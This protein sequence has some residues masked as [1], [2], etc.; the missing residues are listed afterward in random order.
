M[1]TIVDKAYGTLGSLLLPKTPT[2]VTFE[3]AIGA[4]KK[5]Y[6]PKIS[7]VTEGYRFHQ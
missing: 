2:K 4:L 5:H 1:T 3:D 7:V 6:T